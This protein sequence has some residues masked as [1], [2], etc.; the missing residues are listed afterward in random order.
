MDTYIAFA[1]TVFTGFFAILNPITS[2]PTFLSLVKDETPENQRWI[3]K[4]GCV[5]AFFILV[6]FVVLGKSIF[7]VFNITIP[8][9][10]ITGGI[11][12]FYVGFEMLLSRRSQVKNNADIQVSDN[13]IAIS[14]L[15]IP[16]LSGPG[17]IVTGMNFVAQGEDGEYLKLFI[18]VFFAAV[19]FLMNYISFTF[20][21][22]IMKIMGRNKIMVLGKIMGLIL[23]IMGTDMIIK[24]I[25]LAFQLNLS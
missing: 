25:K 5:T 22:K 24:G 20:S 11:L 9:F 23:S 3:A 10:R 15:A 2:V 21:E 6:I 18:V 13:D 4:R 12:L 8:A 17:T 14:P 19:I 7:G 16:M 1:F